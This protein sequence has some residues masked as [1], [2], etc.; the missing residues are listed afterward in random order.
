MGHARVSRVT[1]ERVRRDRL[2][3]DIDDL[4]WDI[5]EIRRSCE[6]Q[7]PR[8]TYCKV[9]VSSDARSVGDAAQTRSSADDGGATTF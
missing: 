1:H 5:R 3:L 4:D 9:N 6:S 7:C 2:P 8:P